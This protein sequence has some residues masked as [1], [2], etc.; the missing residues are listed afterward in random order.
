MEEE[1]CRHEVWVLQFSLTVIYSISRIF[2]PWCQ[3]DVES[4]QRRSHLVHRQAFRFKVLENFLPQTVGEMYADMKDMKWVPTDAC[5][6][7]G[8]L[9]Y[10]HRKD[11]I[12]G[13]LTDGQSWIFIIIEA[14]ELGAIFYWTAPIHLVHLSGIATT[15]LSKNHCELVAGITAHWVSLCNF[16]LITIYVYVR[17]RLT[18]L[19][20]NL[21]KMISS[22]I[23]EIDRVDWQVSGM[24]SY[25]L[26]EPW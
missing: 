13:T 12:H 21:L 14:K 7:L 25:G 23:R 4:K 20:A 22:S 1:W 10:P 8:D 6:D 16:F 9:W 15:L 17:P 24:Y 2:F 18:I 26:V 19:I 11:V 3:F 5:M